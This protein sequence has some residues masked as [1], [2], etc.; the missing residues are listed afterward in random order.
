MARRLIVAAALLTLT[1]APA[2]AAIHYKSTTHTESAQARGNR[3]IQAEGWVAADKARIEFHSSSDPIM[4][5]GNYLLTK[6]G[7]KTIYLVNPE[8][9]TYAA[10]DLEAMLGMVGG[11]MNG[12]GPMLKIQM[13]NPKV[14]K[15]LDED[16]GTL[17][18]MPT[19]HLRFHTTYTMTV[20]VFGMGN[21]SD[22]VMDQDV[23]TTQKLPD[24]ALGVWLRA[25]P[26]RTGNDELDKL[27]RAE[28][29]KIQGIP[30]KNIT[31]STSTEKKKGTK[32]VT[33]TS[34]EVTQLDTAA[35]APAGSFELPA[36]YKETQIVPTAQG[37]Q[38][39]REQEEQGGLRGLL[40]K[41]K[42]GGGSGE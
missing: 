41:K 12:M 4:K 16:G 15:T 23:W 10:W 40:R 32:T 24:V 38:E 8:D 42:T 21:S 11:I 30:L 9:K 29:G 6:D 18:G 20:K 22:V 28:A 17:L 3:D 37:Q 14:E 13:E 19:R 27:V 1:T 2:F 39:N 33:R 35:T 25:N 34:M 31:V 5:Q 26:P 36:G 7:G